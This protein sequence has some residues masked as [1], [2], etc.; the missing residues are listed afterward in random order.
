MGK[1]YHIKSITEYHN[2]LGIPKP[3]HPLIG[4]INHE[5]IQYYDDEKLINKTYEFYTISR[6]NKFCRHDEIRTTLLQ[7]FRKV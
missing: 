3:K 4:L 6:K 5:D 7:I 1:P 2:L